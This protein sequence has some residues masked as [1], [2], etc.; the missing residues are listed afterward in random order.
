MVEGDSYTR[1]ISLLGGNK[2]EPISI[3]LATVI[4]PSPL[5]IRVDGDT[6]DTPGEGIILAERISASLVAG[7]RVITAIASDGQLIYVLDKA[8]M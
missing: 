1:L 6:V 7:D 3:T 5:S 8:V 4:S 2:S